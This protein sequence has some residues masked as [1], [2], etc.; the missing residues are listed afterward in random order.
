MRRGGVVMRPSRPSSSGHDGTDAVKG[1][2]RLIAMMASRLSIGNSSIGETSW[3]PAL[4]TRTSTEPN[5]VS[6]SA[7]MPAIAAGL[8]MSTGR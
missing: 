8:V 4:M 3:I 5:V 2:D 6:P 7:I 1:K